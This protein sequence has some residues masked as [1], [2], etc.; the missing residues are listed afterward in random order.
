MSVV[1]WVMAAAICGGDSAMSMKRYASS[2]EIRAACFGRTWTDADGTVSRGPLPDPYEISPGVWQSSSRKR[3]RPAAAADDAV[4]VAVA[5]DTVDV[6]VADSDADGFASDIDDETSDVDDA[7]AADDGNE[8]FPLVPVGDL[9][10]GLDGGRAFVATRAIAA[11]EVVLLVAP[12]AGALLEQCYASHC[13]G[14]YNPMP[15]GR[16]HACAGGCGVQLCGRCLEEQATAQQLIESTRHVSSKGGSVPP[17]LRTLEAGLPAG[18]H[19]PS[20]C[21]AYRALEDKGALA[22]VLEAWRRGHADEEDEEGEEGE[23]DEDDNVLDDNSATMARIAVQVI[24]RRRNEALVGGRKGARRPRA[25]GDCDAE[26]SKPAEQF[27]KPLVVD[28]IGTVKWLQSHHVDGDS[29]DGDS[30]ADGL[31][32]CT[33]QYALGGGEESPQELAAEIAEVND[34]MQTC[35]PLRDNVTSRA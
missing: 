33:V 3:L 31:V 19:T 16:L 6:A 23:E 18:H 29:G 35:S 32:S 21:R 8:A 12:V 20:E 27:F 11:G 7:T 25:N 4:D 28:E 34:S 22:Q 2:R 9:D 24:C 15:S 14:C 17:R 30:G 26:A 13:A 5:D 1:V 10:G